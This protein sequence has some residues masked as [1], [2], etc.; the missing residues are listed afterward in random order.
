MTKDEILAI[1][2]LAATGRGMPDMPTVTFPGP[3][4]WSG[5]IKVSFSC[6]DPATA[7][8]FEDEVVKYISSYLM[9]CF[10]NTH[11]KAHPPPAQVGMLRY[12]PPTPS[13]TGS[14]ECPCGLVRSTCEYH[15][16]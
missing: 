11:T 16:V 15:K 9:V 1:V 2:A 12:E 13:P 3:S 4:L 5:W 6:A 8:V 7:L 14:H 10:E